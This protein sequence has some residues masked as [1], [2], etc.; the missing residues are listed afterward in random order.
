MNTNNFS[1]SK[2]L[3]SGWDNL[4]DNFKVFAGAMAI[5]AVVGLISIFLN[6]GSSMFKTF[7]TDVPIGFNIIMS[8]ITFIVLFGLNIIS[9]MLYYGVKKIAIKVYD[10]EEIEISDMFLNYQVI[11]RLLLF[12]LVL[13]IVGFLAF[14]IVGAFVALLAT[15]LGMA[16]ESPILIGL[17]IVVVLLLM[18]YV[19]MR[20]F[21]ITYFII[22]NNVKLI[23]AVKYSLKIT[24]GVVGKLFLLNSILAI[25]NLLG[26]IFGLI[27]G[28]IF[29]TQP[30]GISTMSG[31]YNRLAR[32]SDIPTSEITSN[33]ERKKEEEE[34]IEVSTAEN[35]KL[36]GGKIR[37][38]DEGVISSLNVSSDSD[39][40]E[41]NDEMNKTEI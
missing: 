32:R 10:G 4:E 11:L 24:D 33:E 3:S 35:Q 41:D 27:L 37:E 25:T 8:I 30:F 28:S 18:I 36:K 38:E 7:N 5:I 31:V 14:L 23:Q 20:L 2:A 22:D 19:F 21:F 17:L 29:V 26:A 15:V 12:H 9:M 40:E 16:F 1:I 34:K 13:A 39:V 6:V